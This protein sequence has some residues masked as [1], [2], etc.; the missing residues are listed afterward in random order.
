M[1]KLLW[2]PREPPLIVVD[3]SFVLDGWRPA[4]GPARGTQN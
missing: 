4:D 2:Q 1:A 3:G